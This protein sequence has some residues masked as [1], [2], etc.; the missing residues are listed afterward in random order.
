MPET[1]KTSVNDY[2][3]AQD[4]IQGWLYPE[5]VLVFQ[6]IN[7]FQGLDTLKGDLLEIGVYYG[8]SAILM[9]YFTRDDEGLVVCDLFQ[10][11]APTRKNQAEKQFWY[12]QLTQTIFETNYLRFHA[13]LPSMVSCPSTELIRIGLL[14]RNFRFVHIDG[15]H[16]YSIVRQDLRTAKRLLLRNGIVAIDDYRSIH[17]PGVAAATWQEVT[18]GSLIPFCLTPQKMYATWDESN[19]AAFRKHLT[20]WAKKRSDLIAEIET[21]Y[22]WKLLRLKMNA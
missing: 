22:G 9:G 21:V 18:S 13:E 17:T 2:L 19:A 4:C 5:D 12:S 1:R 16:L 11:P 20:I 6:E 10:S 7:A 3:A 8:K 15:S 14:K